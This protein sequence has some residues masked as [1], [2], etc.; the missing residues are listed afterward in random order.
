MQHALDMARE[1]EAA[2]EVPVGA[3]IVDTKNRKIIA[4]S[5]NRVIMDHD[6]TAHAEILA[7]RSAGS[8]LGRERLIECDLYVTLEPCP[9]CAQAISLS[10]IRRLYYGAGDPKSGGVDHGARVLKA[11]SA[12]HK[13]E[14]YSGIHERECAQILKDF[15]E[16]RR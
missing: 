2:G 7:I 5:F 16:K 10:R 14:I 12:H 9:M 1:A 15:F 8:L 3:V 6:P 4:Q 13:P 11:S